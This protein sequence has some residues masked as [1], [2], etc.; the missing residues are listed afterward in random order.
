MMKLRSSPASPF[1]RKVKLAAAILGLKDRIE[2]QDT[3]T[4]DP[5]DSIR[6]QNPLGKIPALVLEDG[7]VL[8]DSAVIVEYLDFI[9]GGDRLF[10]A[11]EARFAVLRDQ[12]LAD[13]IMDAAILR[14]YEKRFKEKQY[15]DPAWDAYQGAKMER[16]L[17]YFEEKTP[18]APATT[19][20][21]T[22]GTLT[23]AC[24]LGYLDMRFA[25]EWRHDHPGLVA[26]LDAFE[27]V[28]SA[29]TD[30]RQPPAPVPENAPA[31]LR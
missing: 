21:V 30:T 18:P 2:V 24:A 23:L 25:G 10:P 28:V 12:T 7:E 9:A 31:Q 26:W 16:G 8:Y 22:A 1:G 14:V 17:A 27:A 5:A 19:A 20:D 4:A 3:N 13:G 15:R 6:N 29:F 11:G